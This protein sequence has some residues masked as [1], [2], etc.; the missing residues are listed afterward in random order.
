MLSYRTI[1][2]YRTTVCQIQIASGKFSILPLVDKEMKGFYKL[3]MYFNCNEDTIKYPPKQARP[4]T[5]LNYGAS[6]SNLFTSDVKTNPLTQIIMTP[7]A[8][9][10]YLN[11]AQSK[12]LIS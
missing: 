7:Y 8:L 3:R 2:P 11:D 9:D 12:S 6:R 5:I 4:K 10:E 1:G